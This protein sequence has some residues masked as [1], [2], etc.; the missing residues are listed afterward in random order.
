MSVRGVPTG[1]W[2]HAEDELHAATALCHTERQSLFLAVNGM[3]RDST[4]AKAR[5]ISD[6][7]RA[8]VRSMSSEFLSVG[9]QDLP[10]FRMQQLRRRVSSADC[11]TLALSAMDRV[12]AREVSQN[13][14]TVFAALGSS[15]VYAVCNADTDL[16]TFVSVAFTVD[17]AER[18]LNRLVQSFKDVEQRSDIQSKSIAEYPVLSTAWLPLP[19]GE[20]SAAGCMLRAEAALKRLATH[21]T[22]SIDLLTSSVSVAFDSVAVM[23]SCPINSPY[24]FVSVSGSLRSDVERVSDLVSSQL[25]EVK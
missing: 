14:A 11:G 4:I 12:G 10:K 25:G 3:S 20:K 18:Q 23:V 9:F 5:A 16:T 8:K 6:L 21:G 17:E 24:A 2:L 22:S 13:A 19:V 15:K 7:A 1:S